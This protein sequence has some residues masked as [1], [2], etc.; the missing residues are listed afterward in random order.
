MQIRWSNDFNRQVKKLSRR[1]RLIL[2]DIETLL[3]DLKQGNRP[4]RPLRGVQGLPV[5]WVRLRNSS[6]RSGK[7]GGF[8][9]VYYYDDTIIFLVMIDT[10]A[11]VDYVQPQHILQIL[12]DAGLD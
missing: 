3:N 7:S 4:G 6:A 1:Y 2:D 9:V 8:R 11:S 10:R 5:Q 12:E